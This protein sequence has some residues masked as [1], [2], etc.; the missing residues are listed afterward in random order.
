MKIKLLQLLTAPGVIEG[1]TLKKRR[2]G[3]HLVDY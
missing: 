1:K 2:E 3:V